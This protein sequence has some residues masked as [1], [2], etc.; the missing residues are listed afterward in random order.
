MKI[1]IDPGHGGHDSGAIG[2]SGLK[3]KDVVLAISLRLVE[4]L[5]PFNAGVKLTRV[6]DR[7]LPLDERISFANSSG[8]ALLLSIHCNSFTAP[9]AGGVE[10]WHSYRGEFG[11][12]HYEEAKRIA[13]ILQR[14]LVLDTGLLNRGI[15]TRLVEQKDSPLYGLDYYAITRKANCPAMIVELGFIS[16]P[17]EEALLGSKEFR[18][19]VA[20]SLANGLIQ[21]LGLNTGKQPTPHSPSLK[22][23]T[24]AF[25]EVELKGFIMEGRSY[26]EV[27]KL[28]ETLGLKVHWDP[29]KNR[30]EITK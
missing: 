6:H 20:R 10:I 18:E 5:A 14:Q 8:A 4:L 17:A 9:N 30:V 15:K 27:R 1:I 23:T 25:E 26:V 29:L 19:K 22:E 3:E 7:S 21:A 28:A 11:D 13:G 24:V 12:R 2:P 16:N